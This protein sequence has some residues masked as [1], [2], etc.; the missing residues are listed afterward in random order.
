VLAMNAAANKNPQPG[1]G[2]SILVA[3]D[4][5][6]TVTTLAAILADEGHVVHTVT[7]AALVLAA[8]QEFKPQVCIIDIEMPRRN[9]YA[10]AREILDRFGEARPLLIAISG[11]W[12]SQTDQ[13]LA[14]TVGFD[15]FMMKPAEP[16]EL[17][18][19]LATAAPRDAA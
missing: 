2:L 8:I 4:E 15:H 12:K 10:I 7:R 6:D 16:A 3:D 5:E 11:K 17:I 14:R 19:L 9:G 18:K 13:L 1:A